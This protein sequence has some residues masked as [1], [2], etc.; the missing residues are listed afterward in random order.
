[1][2]RMKVGYKSF[3]C[4][5]TS[6]LPPDM[7]ESQCLS[8]QLVLLRNLKIL[9]PQV[10]LDM[11]DQLD[12][13]K[14]MPPQP[15]GQDIGPDYKQD[16][17]KEET[18]KKDK[19]SGSDGT[20]RKKKHKSHESHSRHSSADKTSTPS[21]KE[22]GGSFNLTQLGTAVAQACLSM[23]KM[24]Q[25]MEDRHNLRIAD[26]L[27]IKKKLEEASAWVIESMM[28]NIRAAHTP[29][30]TW[31]IEKRLSACIS[32]HWAKAFDELAPPYKCDPE[33]IRAREKTWL[34]LGIWQKQRP[35]SI[36][37]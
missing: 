15:E 22:A 19:L 6:Y 31:R 24:T 27:L 33:S 2:R 25:A 14:V 21:T 28:D 18:P 7:P 13:Q 8:Q 20:D 10:L 11:A 32:A 23:V 26:A 5:S 4:F 3:V 16:D 37:Q 17:S 1:M 34:K 29:A 30:D 36:S 9:E 35:I 12:Q